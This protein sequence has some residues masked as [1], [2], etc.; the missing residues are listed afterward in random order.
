MEVTICYLCG[1]EIEGEAQPMGG[2]P[3]CADCG[4]KVVRNRASV[5]W[6]SLGAIAALVGFVA[7]VTLVARLARP[8]LQGWSLVLEGGV[9]SVVPAVLWL[10]F[11]YFQDVREP[12]PKQLVL[13]VFLLGALLARAVGMPLVNDVF[14]VSAWLN[15]STLY[16]I[17]GSIL[18]VGFTQQFLVYAA[19]RYSVFNSAEFDERVDGVVYTTAAALGYATMINVQYVVESGG[20]DLVSG[21]I[22]I[23]VTAMALASFGGI[24]G[25]FLGRCRFEDVPL[26]WMPV[27]LTLAATLDGLFTYFRGEITTTAIGL[28]GGGYNPWPGLLLGAVVASV[29]FGLLLFLVQ[30]LEDHAAQGMAG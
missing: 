29:T 25:Y 2:R 13:S 15:T 20:L 14:G 9:L 19:V 5:W 28:K 10:A 7:L 1:E 21:I 26:W 3:Y 22:R 30:R 18:V 8:N 11:F 17:L 12:E 27:G 6:S 16:H 23:T 4:A 24:T